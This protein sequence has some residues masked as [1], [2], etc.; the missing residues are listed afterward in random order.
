MVQKAGNGKLFGVIILVLVGFGAYFLF[1]MDLNNGDPVYDNTDP[2]NTQNTYSWENDPRR[3]NFTPVVT[4]LTLQINFDN[5]T[6]I[7]WTNIT[8]TD[9][10]T[11][12]F[13]LIAGK[14]SIKYKI[15]RFG[16]SAYFYLTEINGL[17]ENLEQALYWQY[18]VNGVYTSVGANG[19]QLRDN[20]IVVWRYGYNSLQSSS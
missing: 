2:N 4:N 20:D 13:D 7:T 5:G 10:Y 17:Q 14:A 15:F 12:V 1:T 16:E 8:L 18:W 3:L 19:F 11:S 9:R 6:I